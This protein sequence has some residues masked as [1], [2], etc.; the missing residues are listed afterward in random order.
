[1]FSWGSGGSTLLPKGHRRLTAIS[2][3]GYSRSKWVAA[4]AKRIASFERQRALASKLDGEAGLSQNERLATREKQIPLH[5]SQRAG[6]GPRFG[7]D[8]RKGYGYSTG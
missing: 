2:Q 4:I 8:R 6:R 1:M 7:N 5:P 3:I